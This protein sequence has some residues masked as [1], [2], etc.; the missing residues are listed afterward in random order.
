MKLFSKKT[1]NM[2]VFEELKWKWKISKIERKFTATKSNIKSN[3]IKTKFE[4][5]YGNNLSKQPII[6][7]AYFALFQGNY[8]AYYKI[9]YN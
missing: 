6:T 1:N 7:L 9:A 5:L 8:E 3:F 4:N 2:M